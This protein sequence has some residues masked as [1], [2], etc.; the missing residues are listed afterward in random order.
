MKIG[1]STSG[2]DKRVEI[3]KRRGAF[4]L[5]EL[6]VVIAII[7]ILAAIL[8]PVL[9]AAQ[10]RARRTQCLNNLHQLGMAWVMYPNDNNDKIMSNPAASGLGY[11][12]GANVNLQNWVNGYL[13]WADPTPDNTNTTYL[14][15]ALTGP[16]CQYQVKIFKCPDDTLKCTE[17]G[18]PYDRVRSYSINYCMEGD[19]ENAIK[20][21]KNCPLNAVLWTWSAIPRYGYQKLTDIGTRLKGPG[22]SDA[23]VLTEESADTIDNGCLAWG[24]ST[25]WAN[26]PASDHNNGDNFTFADGHVEYH[27]WVTGWNATQ[28]T[29]ICEPAKGP[30]GGWVGPSV[31]FNPSDY[32]WVT[33]HGTAP[34]P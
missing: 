8:L 31:G 5:I 17:N 14:V 12:V 6:L 19:V 11:G 21:Q 3:S 7:A 15:Q 26:T 33:Q 9:N 23:W 4:T 29:G 13:S 10:E 27:K 32:N 1:F 16:Y 34:Y 2:M 28:H 25:L 30:N 18:M 20:P 22:V 24:S